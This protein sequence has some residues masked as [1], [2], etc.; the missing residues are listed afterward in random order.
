MRRGRRERAR[1][2]R[3]G[4][5]GGGRG[6]REGGIGGRVGGRG[7]RVGGRGGRGG[8]R[9]GRGYRKSS[10]LIL[11]E[12]DSS[13]NRSVTISGGA[14]LNLDHPRVIERLSP[15]LT[16]PLPLF[17]TPPS[18][19]DGAEVCVDVRHPIVETRIKPVPTSP[20][21]QTTAAPTSSLSLTRQAS[22]CRP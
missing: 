20:T 19:S 9:G 10:P 3:E 16:S 22:P 18:I 8:G 21:R 14:A 17:Q 15:L 7:G 6:R 13:A 2:R 4:S 5:R 12:R 1:K 11:K